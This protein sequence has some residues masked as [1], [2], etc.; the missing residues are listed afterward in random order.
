MSNQEELINQC[1]RITMSIKDYVQQ[2][3]EMGEI[4]MSEEEYKSPYADYSMEELRNYIE[5]CKNCPLHENR[6]N[7]VFGA[8]NQE[9]ELMFIGEA[10]GSEEDSQGEPFVGAAGKL[11]TKIINSID[12]S[13]DD[14][15]I[16]NVVKCRPP[17]N[18]NP[19]AD[20]IEHCMPFLLR[21][22]EIIEPEIICTLGAVA[23]HALLDTDEGITKI[24]GEFYEFGKSKLIPTFHPAYLLRN[25]DAKRP[26]WEDMKKIRE[27]L[28]KSR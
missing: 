17:E 12:L 14:V 16:T 6:T 5:E 22:L 24:R 25:Q 4:F 28:K 7:V 10:P 2:K 18:R 3:L 19:K 26:V 21:Q 9:A 8:G 27:E 11:L 15:Y 1:L 23:T 20:E 13:R